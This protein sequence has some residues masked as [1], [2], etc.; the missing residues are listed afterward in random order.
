M[1]FV[2]CKVK[3]PGVGD[4]MVLRMQARSQN[5]ALIGSDSFIGGSL[6]KAMAAAGRHVMTS[7]ADNVADVSIPDGCNTVLFCHDVS[8]ETERH[9]AMLDALCRRLAEKHADGNA[10]HV[11]LFTPAAVCQPSRGIVREDSPT[12]PNGRCGVAACH[13]ELLL[14]AWQEMTSNAIISH[15]FRYGELYGEPCGKE[16]GLGHLNAALQLARQS[17]PIPMR[18]FGLQKRTLTHI[19]DFSRAVATVLSEYGLP[20]IVNIPGERM[21]IAQY[22][23]AI[24]AAFNVDLDYQASKT[25]FDENLPPYSGD[26]VLSS[27]VFRGLVTFKPQYKFMKWLFAMHNS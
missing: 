18:G 25:D 4:P 21:T 22:M 19:D 24:A 6:A 2:R 3:V 27:S 1:E 10:I 11:C 12:R 7:L 14:H 20:R 23:N 26:C 5:V 13:A 15:I 8:L 16:T 17:K 9:A